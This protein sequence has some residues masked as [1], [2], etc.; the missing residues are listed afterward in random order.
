MASS[1]LQVMTTKSR[2]GTWRPENV[3]QQ[4]QFAMKKERLR[5]VVLHPW[6]IWLTHSVLEVL[7]STPVMVT[8]LSVTMMVPWQLE[9]VRISSIQLLLLRA[10]LKNGSKFWHTHQMVVNLLLDLTTTIFIS[11]TQLVTTYWANALSTTPSSHVLIGVKMENTLEVYAVLTNYC[12][13]QERPTIKTQ[14]VLQTLLQLNGLQIHASSDGVLTVFSPLT[15]QDATSTELISPLMATWLPLLTIM[16]FSH[17]S[18]TQ[19]L[20]DQNQCASEVTQNT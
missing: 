3:L 10:I 14:V 18:E 4:E 15:L 16:V 8:L 7:P 2:H 11:M 12:S 1:L 19:L 6:L 20:R 5:E 13:S 9:L 17:S